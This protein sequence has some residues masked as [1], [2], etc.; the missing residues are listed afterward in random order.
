MSIING[1]QF[2]ERI[3]Q[4]GTKVWYHGQEIKGKLSEHSAFKGLMRSQ[5]KLYDLQ[6]DPTK[7][8]LMTWTSE[9]SGNPV[10]TSY[11][12]PR[13]TEDLEKRRLA[14]QEWAK[15]S[16]GMLGRSPDYMNT[17][18][19][20]LGTSADILSEESPRHSEN[21]QNYYE[22]VR[23]NDLSLT[24]TFILPQ[25]NRSQFYIEDPQEMIAAQIIGET[26][27]GV[28]V[29]GARLLATQGATTDELLVFPSGA[30][31]P[32]MKTAEPMAYAFAIP[33]NTP[34]LKFYCR[35]S[36]VGGES[37]FDHPLSSRF[38]EM[39]TIVVFDHV[40]VPWERVFLHGNINVNNRLY[41]DSGFFSQ[42]TH[43]I[44]SKN[45]V[46]IE[47][48][49]GIMKA[50][51]ETIN[52]G[53]YQHVHEKISEVIV[54]LEAMKG[55][56][57]SSEKSAKVNQ[58]GVLTPDPNPLQAAVFYYS[59]F[60]PRMAEIIQLL[61]ASGLVSTPT[62]ADFNSS[63]GDDLRHYLKTSTVNGEEKVRLFRLAWDASIS[64]FGGRQQLYERFFF[65]DPVRLASILYKQ[66]Q[67]DAFEERI[68]SFI[69]D[70]D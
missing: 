25:V 61:G 42:T 45:V 70:N 22:F 29:H 28:I 43:L 23:E 33:N 38:E 10:G 1:N 39:D 63:G 68:R 64:S 34:G 37:H 58:W 4:L 54:G 6:A 13:T 18:I 20:A 35:D 7:Q 65:G 47:S 12:P 50:I 30:R 16:L 31:L 8:A 24:H 3:D 17:T 11:L 67:T 9:T 27:E 53:E 36:F 51:I 60:Y 57:H 62:E 26:D 14:I 46:K 19:M 66:Y 40:L 52:I 15:E 2:I 49:L 55:F 69:N 56:I 32:H 5:A 44:A 21:M 59:K 48:F 41:H